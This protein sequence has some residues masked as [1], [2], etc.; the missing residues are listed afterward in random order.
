M[1]RFCGVLDRKVV[2]ALDTPAP[3][4]WH[5]RRVCYLGFVLEGPVTSAVRRVTPQITL[6]DPAASQ[7]RM[8]MLTT[9]T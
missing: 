1:G 2:N 7:T 8:E 3:K 6:F 4:E 5:V 9:A